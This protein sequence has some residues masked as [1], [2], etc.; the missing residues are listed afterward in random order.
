MPTPTPAEFWNNHFSKSFAIPA[1]QGDIADMVVR[2]QAFLGDVRGKRVLDLGCGLGTLSIA[3]ANMGADVI[4]VDISDVAVSKLNHVAATEGLTIKAYSSNAMEI[5]ALG[6]FDAAAGIM[7]LHH[8]EPLSQFAACLGR[9]LK[10]GATA[11]FYENN[12]SSKL[13]IW[14]RDHIVGKLWVPKYGDADEFPLQPKEIDL[15]RPYFA[16]T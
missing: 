16:A 11:F 6:P 12:A 5:E 7:I 1:P 3:L 13:L 9:S 8:I 4:A 10:P 14:F 15:L 2:L